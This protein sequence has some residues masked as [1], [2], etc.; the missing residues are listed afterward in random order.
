MP[1]QSNATLESIDGNGVDADW[2]DSPATP[3]A[4][5]WTGRARAYYTEKRERVQ[6]LNE[7]DVVL[8]RTLI[9]DNDVAAPIDNDDL[10]TFTYAGVQQT[11]RAKLIERRD[12]REIGPGLRTTRIELADA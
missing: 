4:N 3:G 1:A 10:L 12:L 2:T 9:L 6:S 7:T 5:K 8:R 11:A